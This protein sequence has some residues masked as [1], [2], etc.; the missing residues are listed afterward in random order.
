M[1]RSI[2]VLAL[3]GS[4]RKASF[5]TA[6]IRAAVELA[7]EGM[8][9]ALGETRDLPLYDEDLRAA[10]IPAPAARL[11]AEVERADA[12]LVATPEYNYS[13]PGGVKNA[14]DWASRPPN[15]P[16]AGK[17]LA[18]MGASGGASGA[19]RAQYHLR[20]VAVYLDMHP[21]NKPE[22]FVR[23]A[24]ALFDAEGRLLDPPTRELVR[25][26]L[27]ALAALTSKLRG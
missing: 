24:A 15:Q 12:V 3:S 11:R 6:L 21:V 20:Q 17:A 8:A 7:P 4:L 5:N 14:I 1:S 2:R 10:G 27:E 23:N 26:L 22:V 19:M 13:L 16:F 25:G 18:I 9:I